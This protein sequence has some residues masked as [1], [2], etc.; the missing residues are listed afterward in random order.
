MSVTHQQYESTKPAAKLPVID[1]ADEGQGGEPAL[2]H[3]SR[4]DA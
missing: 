2:S 1:A 4:V 3:N